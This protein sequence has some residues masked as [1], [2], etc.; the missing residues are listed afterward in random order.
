MMATQSAKPEF[1]I[2]RKTPHILI[3]DD[4]PVNRALLRRLL[5]KQYDISEAKDGFEALQAIRDNAYDLVLLD[6]MMPRMNGLDVL[7]E[8]RETHPGTRLPVILVSALRDNKHIVQGLEAGANDYIPKPLDS[9]VVKARVTTQIKAK[10]AFDIQYHALAEL[11]RADAL[12][13]KLLSIA[14]HDLKSPLSS[15]YMAESLLRHLTDPDDPTATSVLDTMK[16][17]LD[18]MNSII[19]EFLDMAAL[20]NGKI[21][22]D[23]QPLDLESV[24]GLVMKHYELT[25]REKGSVIIAEETEGYV[26]ADY[27]RLQQV[28][29][30]LISNALKYSPPNS[31][32]RIKV[33]AEDDASY[34]IQIIDEG[35]GIPADEHDQLFTEFGKLSPR[36]T[37]N[38]SSTGLGLWITKQMIDMMDGEIGVICPDSGGSIFWVKLPAV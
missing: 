7:A 25:S 1:D 29:S 4:E 2:K 8:I 22:V 32:I 5:E 37:S 10:Q 6:I 13:N 11:E 23:I 36:P 38:E 28:L 30:N 19:T 16:Q 24:I 15:V 9:G 35:P 33:L 18:S 12:K 26:M 17:T 21:N 27:V 14:S 3:V 31:E 34:T 20:Q